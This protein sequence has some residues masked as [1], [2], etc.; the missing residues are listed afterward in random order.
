MKLICETINYYLRSLFLVTIIYGFA[1]TLTN[2]VYAQNT[3]EEYLSAYLEDS[4]PHEQLLHRS[5]SWFGSDEAAQVASR[6]LAYQRSSGGWPKNIDYLHGLSS[7]QIQNLRK[8]Q[9]RP[10]ST[11]DNGATYTE[12]SFMSKLYLKT[13]EEKYLNAFNRGLRYLLDAQY[14]NGGWPQYYP[15]RPGYY[16]AIT[17][18]DDAMIGVMGLLQR[19]IRDGKED[20]PFV[21]QEIRERCQ[22]ALDKG[23]SCIIKSQ[24]VHDDQ[25]TAWCAQ[26]DE[27]TL[28]PV[29]A[30]KYELPSRSGKESTGILLFLMTIDDPEPEIKKAIQ[31]GIQWLEKVKIEG[32]RVEWVAI[33]SEDYSMDKHVVQD[34]MAKPIWA[35]F[36]HLETDKA[37]FSDRDGLRYHQLKDISMERRVEY[38]WYGYW[39]D[40]ALKAYYNTWQGR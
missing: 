3:P 22:A 38:A 11:I 20:F 6:V 10:R 1:F 5:E 29:G 9:N 32:L 35:R 28:E 15:L 27:K 26:H 34:D 24:I 33:T 25:L 2:P 39:P 8:K 23:V 4:R 7:D 40:M 12:L 19:I 36:Y 17:F 18:N 37:F 14:E 13:G 21:E 31:A 16:T 30:R